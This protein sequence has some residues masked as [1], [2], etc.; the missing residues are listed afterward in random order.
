MRSSSP[1][2]RLLPFALM[3]AM[4]LFAD[5]LRPSLVDHFLAVKRREDSVLLPPPA[6]TR[7]MSLGYRSALA[8][9]I[10]AHVLVAYGVH[11]QEK[12]LFELAP[13]YLATVVALDA[14]FREP[15]RLADTLITL[16]PQEPPKSAYYAA[17][18][19]QDRGLAEFPYDTELWLISG[20]FL[21]YLA[22]P[23]LPRPERDEFRLEAA[24]RLARS[25]ELVS[26]NENIPHHCITAAS[27]FNDAGRLDAAR[28]FLER[29]LAVTDDPE[30]EGLA[31]GYL[32]TL[33]GQAERDRAEEH[34]AR[35]RA[36]W[37]ADLTF[38]SREMLLLLGPHFDPARCAGRS[39]PSAECATS[40]RARAEAEAR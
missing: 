31:G 3:A 4:L 39:A 29:V 5:W 32:S 19:L 25:C 33:L 27:L 12:R 1:L 26:S 36:L 22:A 14:K 20:Q 23:Q 24:R 15:Y 7:V 40:F 37:A 6:L 2:A 10:F 13:Q 18:A 8:D 21:A 34:A 28:G 38:I 16:Q 30:I 9:L 17:R 11:F 35:L